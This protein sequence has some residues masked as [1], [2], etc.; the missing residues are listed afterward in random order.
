MKRTGESLVELAVS[1]ALLAMMLLWLVPLYQTQEA[2]SVSN[3]DQQQATAL[4]G[5]Q[6]EYLKTF[7]LS[8]MPATA[9]TRTQFSPA[10]AY[11]YTYTRADQTANGFTLAGVTIIVYRGTSGPELA[12]LYGTYLFGAGGNSAGD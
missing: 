9:S 5:S 4:A 7:N 12:R 3:N 8:G 6:L 10:N 1:M 2:G 11:T